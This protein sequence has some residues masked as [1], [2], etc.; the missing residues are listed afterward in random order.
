M[1]VLG[2][3]VLEEGKRKHTRAAKAICRWLALAEG[4]LASNPNE[5][6]RTFGSVDPVPPQTV[7]DIKGNDYRLIAEID[8]EVQVIIVTHFLTHAE[9]SKDRWKRS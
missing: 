3:D 1:E 5:L 7:F 2:L 6:R 8:Y 9:Y 4:C